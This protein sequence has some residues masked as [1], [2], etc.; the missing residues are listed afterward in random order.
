[1]A[2]SGYTPISL[3]YSTTATNVPT[4]ANLVSGELGLNIT[5]GKL[6]YKNNSGVV[7]LLASSAN[8]NAAVISFSGGPTGLTPNTA[9]TGVITLGGLLGTGY[10]GTGLSTFTS[11]NNAIYSTS[12]SALTAGTLP[13]PAGGT[14]LPSVTLNYV[15]FGNGT[16][17]LQ[18]SSSFTFNG[19]TLTAPSHVATSNVAATTTTGVF[20]YGTLSYSDSNIFASYSTSANSY[21]QV[22][23]QNTNANSAASTD[24][25][26]SNDKGT[27]N[28]FYGNFGINSS[29]FVGTGSLNTAN[30]VYLYS[31]SVDL[32][33]GTLSSNAIH[34]VVNNGATDA[35]QITT[36]GTLIST[37][38]PN[39]GS[40]TSNATI[41]PTTTSGQYEVTALATAAN[42][43]APTGT[44]IDGQKLIIRIKDNG[45]ARAL[46]WTTS[47]G[48]YRAEG[49]TLP[50]TT[51]ISTPL[52]IGCVYNAQDSYW[53]VLAVS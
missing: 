39:I 30:S 52:Y 44:V 27:A 49:V 32:A 13:V 19:T 24:F 11:A 41:T 6:Y 14:G 46:T 4:A 1:M 29:N 33:I 38:A 20:S 5:D 26:V 9:S 8:A 18:T 43:A 42:I 47:S 34:F 2:Q 35:A 7:T 50:S 53:D 37:S 15:P 23:L 40:T 21:A 16:S 36:A 51:T 12:A 10:G 45:V 28:S 3:Y 31:N 48:G 25:I 17:A 22:V